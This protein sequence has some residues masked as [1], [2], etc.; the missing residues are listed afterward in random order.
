MRAVQVRADPCRFCRLFAL[1]VPALSLVMG[2]WTSLQLALDPTNPAGG[3]VL[4]PSLAGA[5]APAASGSALLLALVLWAHP[6]RPAALEAELLRT[7]K[8]AAL[9]ALPGYL[10]AFAVCA[11]IGLGLLAARLGAARISGPSPADFALGALAAALDSGLGL[12]L[13]WRFLRRLQAT[14]LSLAGKLIV[15][16]TVTVPLRATLALALGAALSD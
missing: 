8:R 9:V 5:T 7:C 15:V 6:L 11:A 10:L 12:A 16:L 13:A 4:G 14:K 1:S 3:Q 2:A